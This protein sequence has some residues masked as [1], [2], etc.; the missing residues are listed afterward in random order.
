M[1]IL[2]PAEVAAR[3]RVP[4][5][6]VYEKTR[7]R[8]RKP[9]PTMRL[10]RYVRFDWAAV[11]AWLG[12]GAGAPE[13]ARRIDPRPYRTESEELRLADARLKDALLKMPLKDWPEA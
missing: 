5:S 12:D 8:C 3:L 2:T 10:G 11:L 1:E 4:E 9:I 13:T 6:W 7:A